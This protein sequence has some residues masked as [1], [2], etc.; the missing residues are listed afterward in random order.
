M[1]GMRAVVLEKESLILRKNRKLLHFLVFSVLNVSDVRN[2]SQSNFID[3]CSTTAKLLIRT[4]MRNSA[5]CL[6]KI[7]FDYEDNSHE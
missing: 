1:D 3:S 4:S 6:E 5:Q 2:V 7:E